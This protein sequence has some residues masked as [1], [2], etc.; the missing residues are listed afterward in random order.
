[1]NFKIE[2][3]LE[4]DVD[5]LVINNFLNDKLLKLFLNKIELEDYKII[6][7]EH[8]YVDAELGESDI[9]V[10]IEKG[11]DKI[12][13]LIEDKI[14]APAMDLQPERYIERGLKGVEDKKYNS[15][16]T[17]IIAP[18]QYLSTNSYVKKYQFQ[19][20]YE[21]ILD[22]L[23]DDIYAKTI[24][25]KAIEE[26]ET[27]YIVI[28]NE[29]VTKFW[30]KYYNFIKEN[31]PSIKI[32]EIDGPRGSSAAWPELLTDYK[33]VKIM[34]KS[35]RGYMD[36]TFGKTATHIDI[37]NKYVFALPSEFKIVPTGKSLS[38]RLDVPII[39]FKDD[40]DNYINEMHICMSQALKLYDLL[41]QIN[42]L[43]MYHE[44]DN[45]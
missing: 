45:I 17:F 12:G 1:M 28:E 37:F 19:I 30:E 44:I 41:S 35:D 20:S 21:E 11:N 3:V 33:Q 24:L 14:D 9:T 18:K 43:M 26:K 22:Y 38:I 6:D 40:F 16:K 25:N 29:M 8:S 34:H 10:I 2:K 23:S 36:L 5:L 42:V 39:N 32:H 4:R 13:L 7:I 27:G 15:F 31:Y